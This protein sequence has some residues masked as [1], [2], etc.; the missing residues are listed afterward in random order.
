VLHQIKAVALRWLQKQ[1]ISI[2]FSKSIS[3]G[4]KVRKIRGGEHNK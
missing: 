2:Q 3:M 1:N 4:D